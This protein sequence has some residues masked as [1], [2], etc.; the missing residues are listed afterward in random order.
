VEGAGV[1]G[2]GHAQCRTPGLASR[3]GP[4]WGCYRFGSRGD[5]AL[6]VVTRKGDT[7][8]EAWGADA[9]VELLAGKFDAF[10]TRGFSMEER[11]VRDAHGQVVGSCRS[12]QRLAKVA[13]ARAEPRPRRIEVLYP[14]RPPSGM[15]MAHFAHFVRETR[16]SAASYRI[17]P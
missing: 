4:L 1:S 16:A 10:F 7:L 8:Y 2:N 14:P 5:G 17:S 6:I 12:V 11:F 9:P 15:I 3:L 13:S